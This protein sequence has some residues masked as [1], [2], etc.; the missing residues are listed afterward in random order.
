[1]TVTL[2]IYALN[3]ASDE[4]CDWLVP[5]M[6]RDKVLALLKSLPQKPRAR[7]LPL[8]AF[9]AQF[10]QATTFADGSLIDRLLAAVRERTQLPVQRSDFKL[11]QVP[12][13]LFMNLRVVDEQGRQLGMGRHLPALKAEPL[14][15]VML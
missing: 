14:L 5:G 4:R 1:M 2:P 7:L 9:A 15:V 11:E 8:P 6:L 13:H 12:A 10:V 3:Q